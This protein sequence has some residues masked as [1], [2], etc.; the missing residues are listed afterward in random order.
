MSASSFGETSSSAAALEYTPPKPTPKPAVILLLSPA[1]VKP[2]ISVS[3]LKTE[4]N[5]S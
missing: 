2:V 5:F 4:S 3:T 1:K